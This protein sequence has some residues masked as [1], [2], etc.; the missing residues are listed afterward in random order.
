MDYDHLSGLL[1]L[2]GHMRAL[3]LPSS[4]KRGPAPQEVEAPAKKGP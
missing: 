3:V 2:Q 1:Q 4:A